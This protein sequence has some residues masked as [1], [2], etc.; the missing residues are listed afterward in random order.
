MELTNE[1]KQIAQLTNL[2]DR[3]VA[4][5]GEVPLEGEMIAPGL[6]LWHDY[7][8]WSGDHMIL[9]DEGWETGEAKQSYV[10]L[11]KDEGQVLSDFIL[12]EVN[13]PSEVTSGH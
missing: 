13:T 8:E 7:Y 10:D 2:L 1:Q 9:T 12:D 11:A 4:V 5:Y 6:K 3:F